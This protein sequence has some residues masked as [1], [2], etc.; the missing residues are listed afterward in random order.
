[1]EDSGDFSEL[2]SLLQQGVDSISEGQEI[3][4]KAYSRVVLPIDRYIY[5]KPLK[6]LCV[7]GALN[8]TQEMVQEESETYDR[9]IVMLTCSQ[10]VQE[11]SDA[12]VN[13]I[14]VG[15]TKRFRYAFERQG[16]FFSTAKLWH[17]IG[18][19][20]PP[21]FTLQ[22]LDNPASI[23][24][25]QPVVSNSLPLWLQLNNYRVP[26]PTPPAAPPPDLFTNSIPMYPADLV[27]PNLVPP[28]ISVMCYD[29]RAL[30]L[31]TLDQ[32]RNQAQPCSERV[33]LTL[34]GLQNNAAQDFLS[35]VL[36][37]SSET[38]N[39]GIMND[40]PVIVDSHRPDNALLALGMEKTIEFT[41]FYYQ[42]R[43]AAIGRQ[44]IKQAVPAIYLE[45]ELV[46][47]AS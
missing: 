40:L 3:K 32:N 18:H 45:E 16:G 22:L 25:S 39:F 29:T 11:F 35:A 10:A 12:P 34:K 46:Q 24:P 6:Q 21:V 41:I 20:L 44:L 36:Q 5:Y 38:N 17:Y 8:Y 30:G 31:P 37:Y 42:T 28:Y 9:A 27:E 2:A 19:S 1:M 26:F 43:A 13:T 15:T 23:D 47:V 33:R 4:L 14:Y 7:T